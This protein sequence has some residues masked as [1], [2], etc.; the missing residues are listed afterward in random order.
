MLFITIENNEN[1]E[2]SIKNIFIPYNWALYLEMFTSNNICKYHELIM[3][4]D[5]ID[6]IY[7]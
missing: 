7:L 6:K 3:I 1:N 5:D 4:V 2:H